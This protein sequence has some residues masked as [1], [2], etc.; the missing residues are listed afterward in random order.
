MS[1]EYPTNVVKDVSFLDLQLFG[2]QGVGR[3]QR[4]ALLPAASL[5]CNSLFENLVFKKSCNCFPHLKNFLFGQSLPL[6]S[7]FLP[8]F[9]FFFP[10]VT[11][12]WNDLSIKPLAKKCLF[13]KVGSFPIFFNRCKRDKILSF[14]LC[15]QQLKTA[16][17]NWQWL[18]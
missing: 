10:E 15:F 6:F 16:E 14:F 18:N 12:I 8:F 17:R 1:Q 7:F 4:R 5:C 11:P 2:W 13:Q 9:F 3:A